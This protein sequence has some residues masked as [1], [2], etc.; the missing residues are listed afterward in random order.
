MRSIVYIKAITTLPYGD[1]V[2]LVEVVKA[3]G[4]SRVGLVASK[5]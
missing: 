5:S 3:A 1:V 2:K 4:A